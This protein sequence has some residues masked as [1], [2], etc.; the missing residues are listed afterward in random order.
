MLCMML[1]GTVNVQLS[2]NAIIFDL[3]QSN[4]VF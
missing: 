4:A 3:V 1:K 2:S